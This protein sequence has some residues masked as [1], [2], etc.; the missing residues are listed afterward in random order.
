VLIFSLGTQGWGEFSFVE[1]L[2]ILQDIFKAE[3]KTQQETDDHLLAM[4]L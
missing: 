4:I 1:G 3:R 2:C